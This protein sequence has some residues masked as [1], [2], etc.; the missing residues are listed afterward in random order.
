MKVGISVNVGAT[1]SN[2]RSAT[3]GIAE[4]L[5]SVSP[6]A[7][8]DSPKVVGT[9]ITLTN[10]VRDMAIN[11]CD[12]TESSLGSAFSGKSNV[13]KNSCTS[14]SSVI[15]GIDGSSSGTASSSSG[16]SGTAPSLSNSGGISVG[17]IVGIAVGCGVLV[18]ALIAGFVIYKK[19]RV[20]NDVRS[21]AAIAAAAS[22]AAGAEQAVNTRGRKAG[23]T[24]GTVLATWNVNDPL[25]VS[26]SPS[27]PTNVMS[28]HTGR[29]LSK[30]QVDLSEPVTPVAWTRTGAQIM[31][32]SVTSMNGSSTSNTA[33]RTSAL[34]ARPPKKDSPTGSRANTPPTQEGQVDVELAPSGDDPRRAW[35][36]FTTNLQVHDC[37]IVVRVAPVV[38]RVAP[39]VG[40][41]APTVGRVAPVVEREV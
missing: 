25:P 31:D 26:P 9:S 12:A 8:I 19:R 10:T 2:S 32:A 20:S 33:T 30:P 41:V 29:T 40:R 14:R 16:A 17:A 37:L 7:C 5:A 28:F 13:L 11:A 4:A 24:G 23:G 22:T 27:A 3:T 1:T 6:D 38:G 21:A 39:V 15:A 34:M 36:S 18:I 35:N